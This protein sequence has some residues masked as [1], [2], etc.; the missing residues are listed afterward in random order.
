MPG[1]AGASIGLVA[2][3]TQF[4]AEYGYLVLFVSVSIDQAGVPIPAPPLLLAAGAM[5]GTGELD[6][7]A[8]ILVASLGSLPSDL[9]WYSLGRRRGFRVLRTL[10]RI[11]IEPDSCVRNTENAFARHGTRSLVIAKFIP[12]FQTAAPPLAGVFKMPLGRFLLY[13]SISAVLW[14]GTFLL[15]G[16]AFHDQLARVM[17]LAEEFGAQAVAVLG[18]GFAAYLVV[19]VVSRQRFLRTLRVARLAP[20][21]A[22]A[23]LESGRVS[24]VDLR[25]PLERAADPRTLPGARAIGIDEIDDRHGEIPRDRDVILFCS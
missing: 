1:S 16:Y 19:K 24:V 2:E 5:A 4:L 17:T 11:S 7:G 23:L 9:L 21:E 10:C 25:H 13:D 20:E 14:S 12:G 22:H 18:A 8:A 6:L 15:L 3:L